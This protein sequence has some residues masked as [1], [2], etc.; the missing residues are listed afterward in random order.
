MHL[1]YCFIGKKLEKL[2][3]TR[4]GENM[5]LIQNQDELQKWPKDLEQD[6]QLG[7]RVRLGRLSYKE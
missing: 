6:S 4:L 2:R 7:V 5:S 1:L 3:V